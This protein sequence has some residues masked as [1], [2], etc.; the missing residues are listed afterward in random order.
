MGSGLSRNDSEYVEPSV[1]LYAI[2]DPKPGGPD[3]PVAIA[4]SFSWSAA[5]VPPI[6]LVAHALWVELIVWGVA[7]I[8]VVLSARIIGS[9][10]ATYLYLLSAAWLG[11]AAPGLRQAALLRGGWRRRGDCFAADHELAQLEAMR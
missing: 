2:L 7:L 6:F 4:D 5:L 9:E 8:A 10:A 1:T 3:L 11:F